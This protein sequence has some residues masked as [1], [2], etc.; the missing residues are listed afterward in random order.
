[1]TSACTDK[2]ETIVC[3][4]LSSPTPSQKKYAKKQNRRLSSWVKGQMQDALENVSQRRGSTLV[5][6]SCAYTSQMDSRWGVLLGQRSGDSFRCFDGVVLHADQNAARNILARANAHEI[7]LYMPYEHVKSV[8][9]GRTERFKKR[10]GLLIQ[11]SSCNG[12]QITF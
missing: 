1:M 9:L 6:V 7:R 12:E 2:A 4:G 3:E 11:D 8:L 5:L 10:M